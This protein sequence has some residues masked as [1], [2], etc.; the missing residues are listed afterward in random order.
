MFFHTNLGLSRLWS[1]LK[2][3]FYLENV[4]QKFCRLPNKLYFAK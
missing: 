4:K 2:T 3:A 1:N